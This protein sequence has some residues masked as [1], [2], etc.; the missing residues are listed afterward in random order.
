MKRL[1]VKVNLME[2]LIERFMKINKKNKMKFFNINK[3]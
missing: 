3:K 1:F 2:I